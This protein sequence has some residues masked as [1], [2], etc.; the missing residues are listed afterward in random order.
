MNPDSSRQAQNHANSPLFT[1]FRSPASDGPEF[2]HSYY[3]HAEHKF[4]PQHDLQP[5]C[6]DAVRRYPPLPPANWLRFSTGP[7][8][9]I[10]AGGFEWE[11]VSRK[12]AEPAEKTG[13]DHV[14][15]ATNHRLH[16]PQIDAD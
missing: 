4:S 15:R 2:L 1:L 8:R 5:V 11:R 16:E 10:A 6:S 3:A 9:P 12:D 13:A 14:A 7:G